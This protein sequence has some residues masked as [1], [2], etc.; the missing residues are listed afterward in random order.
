MD[1]TKKAWDERKPFQGVLP[2]VPPDVTMGELLDVLCMN[3]VGVAI[4]IDAWRDR[5]SEPGVI[6]Y[7]PA[8]TTWYITKELFSEQPPAYQTFGS[9]LSYLDA[10]DRL[11]LKADDVEHER[12]LFGVLLLEDAL[13]YIAAVNG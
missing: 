6:R 10:K 12:R 8:D 4:S 5:G 11:G 1:R 13:D 3:G 7:P 9:F 2:I